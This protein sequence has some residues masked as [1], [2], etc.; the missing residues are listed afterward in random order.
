MNSIERK[1]TI[2]KL[3]LVISIALL[4]VLS[5]SLFYP[6]IV[7]ISPQITDSSSTDGLRTAY[8]QLKQEYDKNTAKINTAWDKTKELNNSITVLNSYT[9]K[10]IPKYAIGAGISIILGLWISTVILYIR[11][12]RNLFKE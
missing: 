8:D 2:A 7:S 9:D 12:S 11:E 10:K 1:R 4:V 3:V 5:L 6:I